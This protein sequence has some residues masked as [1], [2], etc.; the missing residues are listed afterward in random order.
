MAW[1][2]AA[3][4]NE[5]CGIVAGDGPAFEGGRPLRFHGLVNAA[6]SPYRYLIEPGEQLR[7]MLA[8]DDAGEEVWAI[9]HSHVGSPAVPSATDIELAFYPEALYLICSLADPAAPV[10]RAWRI[11]GGAVTEVPIEIGWS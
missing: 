10:L 1:A 6:A 2:Q 3:A 7:T 9:F 5:A 8:I 11:V 4:P